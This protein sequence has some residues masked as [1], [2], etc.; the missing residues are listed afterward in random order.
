MLKGQ[1]P[2]A[3]LPTA[4]LVEER[5]SEAPAQE[6]VRASRSL[7]QPAISSKSVGQGHKRNSYIKEVF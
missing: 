4:G 3:T 1:P 2:P 6:A 5:V 7:G